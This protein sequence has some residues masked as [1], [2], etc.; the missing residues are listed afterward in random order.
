FYHHFDVV[1]EGDEAPAALTVRV[2]AGLSC[3]LAGAANLL[4]TLPA[5]LGREVRVLAAP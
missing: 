1:R 2:C 5:I 3:E 4:A